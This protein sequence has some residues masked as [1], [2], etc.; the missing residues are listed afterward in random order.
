MNRQSSPRQLNYSHALLIAGLLLSLFVVMFRPAGAEA[1]LPV[2]VDVFKTSDTE[3]S[4]EKI[5]VNDLKPQTIT[6]RPYNVRLNGKSS[7]TTVKLTGIPL[8]EFLKAG[9]VETEGVQFVKIRFGDSDLQGFTLLPLDQANT[10]RPPMI[11][12]AGKIPGRGNFPTPAILPG[13]PN[14]KQAIPQDMITKFKTGGGV[15]AIKLVPAKPG[16]R[17]MS[18]KINGADKAGKNG[19]YTLTANILRGGKSGART[20]YE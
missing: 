3:G 2:G 10:E 6:D 4:R 14:F 8:L 19:Q 13:Q 16:A 12:S 5:D 18:V 9:K 7:D 11:L 1:V 15:E 17:I 20:T